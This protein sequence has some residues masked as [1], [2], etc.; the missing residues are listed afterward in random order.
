MSE[1]DDRG[2]KALSPGIRD[3]LATVTAF[4]TL[5]WLG[6]GGL[7]WNAEN[8]PGGWKVSVQFA[9]ALVGSTELWAAFLVA[10]KGRLSL[11][12]SLLL[13]AAA[14]FALWLGLIRSIE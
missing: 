12:R 2:S 11:G 4:A 9:V 8:S 3:A 7:I 1:Q 14:T 6:Y 5:G 10:E 13:L